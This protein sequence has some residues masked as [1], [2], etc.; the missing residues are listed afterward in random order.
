SRRRHTIFSRDWSSDVCSS[1]L[2]QPG[3]IQNRNVGVWRLSQLKNDSKEN[4]RDP[5]IEERFTRNL[6]L[7]RFWYAS[8]FEDPEYGDGICGKIGRASCRERAAQCGA[9][10][11]SR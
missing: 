7:K 4:D 3:N 11:G 8:L 1:D 9:A 10:G 6:G 2:K 5:V